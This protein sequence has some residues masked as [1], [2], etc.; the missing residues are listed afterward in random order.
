MG[1]RCSENCGCE[2]E[3]MVEGAEGRKIPLCVWCEDGVPCEEALKKVP[4]RA[5]ARAPRS[6]TIK[7]KDPQ[8]TDL[9]R[10]VKKRK[11]DEA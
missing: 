5:L 2:T 10:E 3:R 7:V 8:T 6:I 9:N 11:K 1:L 4:V